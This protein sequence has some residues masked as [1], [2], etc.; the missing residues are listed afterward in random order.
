MS[1]LNTKSLGN[2][3]SFKEGVTMC[4]NGSQRP[5]KQ[6]WKGGGNRAV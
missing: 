6:G 5:L 2:D 3:D 1:K 4:R